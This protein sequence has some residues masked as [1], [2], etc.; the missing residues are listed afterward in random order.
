MK[1]EDLFPPLEATPWDDPAEPLL[2]EEV[3]QEARA[4]ALSA[5]VVTQRRTY[6]AADFV[7]EAASNLYW[8]LPTRQQLVA[9]AVDASIPLEHWRIPRL[10]PGAKKEPAPV[11]PS[12]DI[13]RI[14]ADQFVEGVTWLPGYD[15]IVE[16]MLATPDGIFEQEGARMLN[17]YR[18][19]PVPNPALAER[20]GP[21]VEHVKR[22]FPEVR[23]HEYFFDYC[24]HMLQRPEVKC[25]AAIVLS[26]KQGVGKDAL[27]LPLREVV[28]S[29]NCKNV[30][31]DALFS[32]YNPY[33]QCVMLTVDEVRPQQEDHRA[34]AMY[35]T[36]KTLMASP[37]DILPMNNKHEKVRYVANVLRLFMTTNDRL[38]LHLPP[39]DRRVMVLDSPLRAGWHLAEDPEY[40]QRLFGW[41]QNGGAAAVGG[42]LAARSLA[43]FDAQG[44]VPK[45]SAWAEIQQSWEAP[46][47]EVTAALDALGEPDVFLSSEFA[48]LLFD[49][50]DALMHKM[51][52][53]AFVHRM[54]KAGYVS[55]PRPAGVKYWQRRREGRHVKS[56]QAYVKEALG[57][58]AEEK[59]KAAVQRMD[60]LL[61]PAA[62][63][64]TGRF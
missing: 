50:Q 25:N 60:W 5:V 45:T 59:Q 52:S 14:E 40:F 9:Q 3:R 62:K 41:I 17:L 53:K 54:S 21:W 61:E 28:G 42:W 13:L 26:G 34:T 23:E 30:S 57:W 22:L 18:A 19:A 43:N 4:Q 20:A 64:P 10:P 1:H 27:L 29:W 58:S 37:P 16:G 15:Q 39:D 49:G 8:C 51:K 56:A 7:Y 48:G 44:P 38:A 36:M 63:E 32:I 11:P 47:D 46:D 24:A 31:P 6:R 12:K 2:P 55:V 35:D 33:V